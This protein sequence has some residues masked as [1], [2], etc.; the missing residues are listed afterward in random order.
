MATII[1]QAAGAYLGGLIGATA[2]TVGTAAGAVAG[3]LIDRALLAG[4]RHVE[5][6]RLSSARPFTAEDGAPVP[7]LYGT[8]RLSGT[9]IW[10]TR[11]EEVRNT[12]RQGG[13]GGPKVTTYTY[14]ANAAFGLCEGEIACIRRVWADG[15]EL[16]LNG[17]NMRVHRG[18]TD[19]LPDPLIEARQ[20][21]GN[22]PAYRGTAYVVFE[23]LPL[24]DYGNRLPQLQFEVIRPVGGLARGVQAVALIPGSTEFGYAPPEATRLLREGE[25]EAVNRHVLFGASDFA[26]S[27]DELQAVCPNLKHVALVVAWFGD[28]LRAGNCTVRPKVVGGGAAATG[29]TWRVSDVEGT[30]APAVSQ[31]GGRAAYGGTPSDASVMDAIGDLKARGLSVTLY[32]FIMMD[33]PADNE[34]P[35]PHGAGSQAAYPWRGR[36][37]CDPAPGAAMSADTTAAARTQAGA[38]FGDAV[39]GHFTAGGGQVHFSGAADEWGYRR[40]VLH[41]A[42][43][44]AEARG[45]HVR[46]GLRLVLC[47]R[48]SAGQSRSQRHRG[49]RLRQ[50]VGLPPQGSRELVVERTFQSA[51]RGRGRLADRL[52]SPLEADLVHRTR[53]PGLRQGTKPAERLP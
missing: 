27:V 2:A 43:L 35:D 28:D 33:I 14:F 15:R 46:R 40:M 8:A 48:G 42:R 53:L 19:Q 36:I 49:R 22:T 24:D 45:D 50:A 9:V 13:K 52:G 29:T 25:A 38:F 1:L 17:V 37:T 51:W 23:R 34:L 30:S 44:A 4:T 18:T 32:P 11:F 12:E 3:Y 16:D 47:G 21:T 20:G 7:R 39:P 41:Y 31:A 10:A 5:G 26:A 6:P